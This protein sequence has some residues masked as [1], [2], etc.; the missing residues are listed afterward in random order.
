[1]P[2]F[3]DCRDG[4][5]LVPTRGR[6]LSGGGDIENAC[7]GRGTRV[8]SAAEEALRAAPAAKRH[9]LREA[10]TPEVLRRVQGARA[11]GASSCVSHRWLELLDGIR[12]FEIKRAQALAVPDLNQVFVCEDEAGAEA[13]SAPPLERTSRARPPRTPPNRDGRPP[14][15]PRAL[16]GRRGAACSGGGDIGTL[17]SRPCTPAS[18]PLRRRHSEQHRA[19]KR[20]EGGADTRR[21]GRVP[22]R[23]LKARGAPWGA[24]CVSHRWLAL[25]RHLRRDQGPALAA[26]GPQPVLIARLGPGEAR[27]ATTIATATTRLWQRESTRRRSSG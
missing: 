14:R 1:M 16:L 24:S 8:F 21:L 20:G 9:R 2:P 11:W 15:Q 22:L 26:A 3:H 23:G 19:K 12:G 18:S 4:G 10:P 5:L 27:R 13:A 25:R 7:H 17:Q 6:R